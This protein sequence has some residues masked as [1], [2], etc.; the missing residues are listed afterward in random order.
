LQDYLALEGSVHVLRG[1]E[2]LDAN[3]GRALLS[4][5]DDVITFIELRATLGFLAGKRSIRSRL[6]TSTWTT[7]NRVTCWNAWC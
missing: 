5:D 2:V 4:E 6:A 3:R 1:N 7:R